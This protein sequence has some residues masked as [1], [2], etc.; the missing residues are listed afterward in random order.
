M[1]GPDY[2]QE[3]PVGLCSKEAEIH[4]LR[5]ENAQ[6]RRE[7]AELR[8]GRSMWKDKQQAAVERVIDRDWDD[9]WERQEQRMGLD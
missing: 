8:A 9:P 3:E 1:G 2:M 6:L 7:N 4:R 5:V